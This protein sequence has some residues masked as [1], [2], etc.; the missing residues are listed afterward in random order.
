MLPD[1]LFINLINVNLQERIANIDAMDRDAKTALLLLLNGKMADD[2]T[3][4]KYNEKNIL[5]YQGKNYI[6][7]ND[8]L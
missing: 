5:F 2:W 8:S 1:G 7:K 4:E 3:L 6:P